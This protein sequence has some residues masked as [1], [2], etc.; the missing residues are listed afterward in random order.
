MTAQPAPRFAWIA[1]AAIEA[2]LIV[3]AVVLGF[4][5]NEW[6]ADVRADRDAAVALERIAQ[7]MESNAAMLESVIPYHEAVIDRIGDA[8]AGIDSGETPERG[9]F[10]T[11]IPDLL[12]RGM[13]EPSL[14]RIA[15]DYAEQR[16]EMDPLDYALVSD[17]A[18]IYTAQES[19]V[20]ST[21]RAIVEQ[22]FGRI[23][24]VTDNELRPRLILMRFAFQELVA[25]E[26]FLLSLQREALADLNGPPE[27]GE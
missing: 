22:F 25:Q 26:R 12:P 6:R 17:L 16:G 24:G 13:Q 23:E 2:T 11:L 7:E 19:G 18:H 9:V 1:R 10:L 21:W 15:W 4:I 3:F 20:E 8:L 27:T 5:V 14:S